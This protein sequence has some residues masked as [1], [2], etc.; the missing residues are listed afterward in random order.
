MTA[1][2]PRALALPPALLC[3]VLGLWPGFGPAGI[4]ASPWH[5]SARHWHEP[6]RPSPG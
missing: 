2:S 3:A 6:L 1:N 5:S 4:G